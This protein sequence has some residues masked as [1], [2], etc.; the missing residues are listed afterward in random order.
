MGVAVSRDAGGLQDVQR[1]CAGQQPLR[2]RLLRLRQRLA[3]GSWIR[4]TVL[5]LTITET[6]LLFNL[7]VVKCVDCVKLVSKNHFEA[8]CQHKIP[9]NKER[10][11]ESCI[12]LILHSSNPSQ[13][14]PYT[15]A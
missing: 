10:M 4:I 3:T 2:R 13:I 12:F 1:G 9:P 6:D 15:K 5:F 7:S 11:S 8:R 14:V